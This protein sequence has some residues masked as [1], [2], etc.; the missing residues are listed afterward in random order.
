MQDTHTALPFAYLAH[1]QRS[2]RLLS[3]CM[4][5]YLNNAAY[6]LSNLD[7]FYVLFCLPLSFFFSLFPFLYRLRISTFSFCG[8]SLSLMRTLIRHY[9]KY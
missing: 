8:S 1:V 7:S 6:F 9:T 4:W 3:Y 2:F 5:I